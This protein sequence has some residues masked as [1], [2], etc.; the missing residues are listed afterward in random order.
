MNKDKLL[1]QL[2][3]FYE[4]NKDKIT[5]FQLDKMEW[6]VNRLDYSNWNKNVNLEFRT[7]FDPD[8]NNPICDWLEL[9]CSYRVVDLI[10]VDYEDETLDYYHIEFLKFDSMH[11]DE[12]HTAQD[13]INRFNIALN[14]TKSKV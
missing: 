5:I 4:F 9:K 7:S 6:I 14:A 8:E 10:S 12:N 3:E 2:H 13:V 1:K 11:E